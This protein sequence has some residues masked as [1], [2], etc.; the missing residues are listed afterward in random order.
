MRGLVPIV[1]KH[2][3][4]FLCSFHSTDDKN[5]QNNRDNPK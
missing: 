5:S 4:T 2:S 1:S 3:D